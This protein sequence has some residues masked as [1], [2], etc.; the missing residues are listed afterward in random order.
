MFGK[1]QTK[2]KKTLINPCKKL[3]KYMYQFRQIKS[4]KLN[5]ALEPKVKHK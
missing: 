3:E 2:D 4:E 1:E 5:E